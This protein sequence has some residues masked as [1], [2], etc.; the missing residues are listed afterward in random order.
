MLTAHQK[1]GISIK[2]NGMR[3]CNKIDFKINK[4]LEIKD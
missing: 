4:E 1:I 3:K 2:E